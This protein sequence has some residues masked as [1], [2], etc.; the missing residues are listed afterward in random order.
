MEVEKL[1]QRHI[2]I[3]LAMCILYAL[4]CGSLGLEYFK[5]HI[6]SALCM[7][8]RYGLIAVLVLVN[9]AYFFPSFYKT[10]MDQTCVVLFLITIVSFYHLLIQHYILPEPD[11]CKTQLPMNVSLQE[12]EALIRENMSHSCANTGPTFLKISFTTV[13]CVLTFFLFIY[14]SVCVNDGEEESKDE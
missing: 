2:G 13:T 7:I 6:P 9:I 8:E 12:L 11:F 1:G 14:L 4:I 10:I 5:V 3:P